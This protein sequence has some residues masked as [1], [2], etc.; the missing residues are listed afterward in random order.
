MKK[1][2]FPLLLVLCLTLSACGVSGGEAPS[3]QE[4]DT[5]TIAATTY[6]VY[7]FTRAVV[8]EMES[9]KVSAV[10]NQPMSCL[11]D[12]T[13]SVGDMKIIEGADVIVMNGVGLEDFMDDAL[14]ASSAMVIDSSEGVELLPY[15]GHEDHDHGDSEEAGDHFDPHIWMDPGRA[16]QMVENI[17][18]GLALADPLHAEAYQKR[19]Q[20]ASAQLLNWKSTLR[21]IIASDQPDLR[22]PHRELITFHDGF[23]YFAQA[24]DLDILKAIEEE[25]GS[26]A[27]AAEIREIV[28][29]IRT[30]EIPAIFTEVNGSDST[31]QA[32]AR[33]TG[34]AVCPLSMIMSGD[35]DGLDSYCDAIS[36]NVET[37]A[38]ALS[39]GQVRVQ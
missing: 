17:G 25:E 21:D 9:V 38:N 13:L 32:I 1:S 19:A 34:V 29:L 10:I 18:A 28:S 11:H 39:E 15:E 4:G 24:F 12:Y 22:L 6:P 5:L 14:A 20:D 3:S 8:G 16:A 7:L 30:Y 27:S 33:E 36:A 23:Q 26:E 37:I 35:G 2:I 31:A